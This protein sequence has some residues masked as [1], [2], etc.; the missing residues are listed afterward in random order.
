M[1]KCAS[2]NLICTFAQFNKDK[3]KP[4][5]LNSTC[6]EC[7][8]IITDRYLSNPYN[9]EK[10]RKKS[11]KWIRDNKEKG[12]I[13]TA[14]WRAAHPEE[15]KEVYKRWASKNRDI[16][17]ANKRYRLAKVKAV[18]PKWANRE[19]MRDFHRYAV[20]M[21]KLSGIRWE[22]DHQVPIKSSYVCGFNCEENLEIIPA[23]E[24]LKKSNRWW[25]D[26][27]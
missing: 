23:T 22:V 7:R 16:V 27:W 10:S 24:N 21:T 14:K 8:K 2:C 4:D 3:S 5:G 13:A 15:N 12:R 17:N 20:L 1:K 6:R 18:T 11:A 19:L 9:L 25:P 26:M